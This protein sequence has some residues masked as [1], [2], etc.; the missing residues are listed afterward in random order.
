M[1]MSMT[2]PVLPLVRHRK[3]GLAVV[4]SIKASRHGCSG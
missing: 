2:A 4:D 1:L 3:G